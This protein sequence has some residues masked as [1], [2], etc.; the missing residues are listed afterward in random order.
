ML[1]QLNV[2]YTNGIRLNIEDPFKPSKA[3]SYT[4]SLA[5]IAKVLDEGATQL[6]G[7]GAAFPFA[8]PSGYAGFT[9]P[10]TFKRFNRA[11]ALRVALY[12]KTLPK[13]PRCCRKLL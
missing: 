4:E 10:A 8:L 5:G 2:Q 3:V 7:A 6:D 11:I 12:Q 13:P 1:Y 9:T